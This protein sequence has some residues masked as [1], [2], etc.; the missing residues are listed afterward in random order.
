M[1]KKNPDID[2]QDMVTISK[3]A[4][5]QDNKYLSRK[6]KKE[7]GQAASKKHNVIFA[8]H[9]RSKHAKTITYSRKL[10]TSPVEVK[11]IGAT[12]PPFKGATFNK[13]LKI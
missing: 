10:K 4:L 11:P 8:D 5:K 13:S 12:S 7:K 9:K 3:L 2:K 6:Q 1:T